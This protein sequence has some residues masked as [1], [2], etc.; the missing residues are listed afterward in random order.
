VIRVKP[1]GLRVLLKVV[2]QPTLVDG[3]VIALCEACAEILSRVDLWVMITMPRLFN[4]MNGD[5]SLL[6]RKRF[7]MLVNHLIHHSNRNRHLLLLLYLSKVRPHRRVLNSDVCGLG[8]FS[9][10]QL[11]DTL[12]K[13]SLKNPTVLIIQ[14][15]YHQDALLGWPSLLRNSTVFMV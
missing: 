4:V 1:R 5:A 7:F 8:S 12:R 10:R 9:L 3:M 14:D 6:A 2:E 15:L 13:E 11:F